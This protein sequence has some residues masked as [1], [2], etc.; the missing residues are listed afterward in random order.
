[1]RVTR[2]SLIS[3][4]TNT[5]DQCSVGADCLLCFSRALSPLPRPDG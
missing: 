3:G 4:E 5:L 1:M 2:Q